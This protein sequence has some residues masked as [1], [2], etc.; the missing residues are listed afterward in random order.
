MNDKMLFGSCLGGGGAGRVVCCA[1]VAALVRP[2]DGWEGE[3]WAAG[4]RPGPQSSRPAPDQRGGR[5]ALG[6]TRCSRNIPHSSPV[7]IQRT[8]GSVWVLQEQ[9][10]AD[11]ADGGAES[12]LLVLRVNS[13]G[14]GGVAAPAHRQLR[15]LH[16][17]ELGRANTEAMY[18]GQIGCIS[19]PLT[20]SK[21]QF[22]MLIK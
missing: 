15:P 3:D 7:I 14:G 1:G 4:P 6:L 20:L 5:P 11:K 9:R 8:A 17:H 2:L 13:E 21:V 10:L 18:S 19:S 16:N 12:S 22:L